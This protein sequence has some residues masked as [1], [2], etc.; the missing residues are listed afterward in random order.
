MTEPNFPNN[1]HRSPVAGPL[2][3]EGRDFG[4][5]SASIGLWDTVFLWVGLKRWLSAWA[6]GFEFSAGSLMIFIG[7]VAFAIGLVHFAQYLDERDRTLSRFLKSKYIRIGLLIAVFFIGTGV[8]WFAVDTYRNYHLRGPETSVFV[9]GKRAENR[10]EIIL[11][12]TSAFDSRENDTASF[13]IKSSEI[14]SLQEGKIITANFSMNTENNAPPYCVTWSSS[15][16]PG[17]CFESLDPII[18]A[19]T[20]WRIWI[21][22]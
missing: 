12:L 16:V 10:L 19:G 11:E 14:R 15:N 3:L 13:E 7:P 22:Q 20:V 5:H 4:Y 18:P 17:I 21:S 6:I 8:T 9:I 2:R 1:K